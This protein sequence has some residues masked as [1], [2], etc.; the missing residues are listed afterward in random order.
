M[1]EFLGEEENAL[2]LFLAMSSHKSENPFSVLC[3]AKSG[4]GVE[5]CCL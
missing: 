2:I 3:L 1:S 5:V 4:I